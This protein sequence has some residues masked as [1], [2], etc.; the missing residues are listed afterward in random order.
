MARIAALAVAASASLL[1]ATGAYAAQSPIAPVVIDE[2]RPQ[3]PGGARDAFIELR[4]TTSSPINLNDSTGDT[5]WFLFY[6]SPT[7]DTGASDPGWYWIAFPD[8]TIIPAHGRLLVDD[9]A[10][11]LNAV[12]AADVPA[13]WQGTQIPADGGV[14]L[15]SN[16]SVDEDD[17][18]FGSYVDG[19]AFAGVEAYTPPGEADLGEGT[20][21]APFSGTT[22][23][24]SWIR[25]S[26]AGGPIDTGDFDSGDN[27]ADFRFVGV[28][29]VG[30]SIF[31]VPAPQNAAS[32]TE[33]GTAV[34]ALL[35]DPAFSASSQPNR[36]Y[37][38]AN[39][40]L[41]IRRKLKNNGT[42]AITNLK[43]RVNEITTHNSPG[44]DDPN[45]AILEFVD[46][47]DQ[48]INGTPTLGLDVDQT[49]PHT[50]GL[51]S[52]TLNV[53]VTS[54]GDNDAVFDPGEEIFVQF[55]LNV[56]RPGAFK[57]YFNVES[58]PNP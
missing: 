29:G 11:S 57:F 18:L 4:N 55:K 16:G 53:P 30:G 32:P 38:A 42:T 37:D 7:N 41:Y 39:T 31:G 43:L 20:P 34:A 40:D 1:G 51:N 44:S 48:T 25:R 13:D 2:L 6:A 33:G 45:Q 36:F 47:P 5:F 46:A 10:Y 54:I 28:D 19:V 3:G 23:Q 21:L 26:L 27:A 58:K 17:N 9:T 8:D 15:Y 14:E 24:Y 52:G 56:V 22:A 12:A 35:F 50:G 49:V